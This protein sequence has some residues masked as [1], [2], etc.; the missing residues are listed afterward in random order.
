MFDGNAT[1]PGF[2]DD[3][4]SKLQAMFQDEDGSVTGHPGAYVVKNI[5]FFTSPSCSFIDNWQMS[6]CPHAYA[7]VRLTTY[8]IYTPLLC[9]RPSIRLFINE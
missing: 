8:H 4:E 6:V 3:T 1:I 2:E 9:V 5:P 7:K